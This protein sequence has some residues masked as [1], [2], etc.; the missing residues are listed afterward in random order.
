MQQ[1]LRDWEANR[2]AAR[3]ST[4]SLKPQLDVAY[5]ACPCDGCSFRSDCARGMACERY[6]MFLEGSTQSR[7]EAVPC[8]PTRARFEALS[9]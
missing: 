1:L 5:V 8:V 3:G 7:W 4:T 6:T 2:L 9:S